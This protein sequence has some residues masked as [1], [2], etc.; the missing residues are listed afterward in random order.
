M[1]IYVSKVLKELQENEKD[2]L[3]VGSA[4]LNKADKE[5]LKQLAKEYNKTIIFATVKDIIFNNN[6]N[7]LVIV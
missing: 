1:N 2:I 6:D 3:M 5:M 7:I 4:Q